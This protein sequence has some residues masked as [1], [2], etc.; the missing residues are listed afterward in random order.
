M[1]RLI[2]VLF[3]VLI[4]GCAT[5]GQST[6]SA[7]QLRALASDKNFSAVC[8]TI[9]GP[10][11]TGKFVYVNVDKTVVVNG[12][13]SVDDKCLVTMTNEATVKPSPL[14]STPASPVLV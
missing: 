9:M 5:P 1:Q 11:G 4:S 3:S 6:M 13:I 2:S 8:S 14:V 7:D 10:W 12:A